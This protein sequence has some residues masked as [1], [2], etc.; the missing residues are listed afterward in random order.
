MS[1]IRVPK[2][3]VM[4]SI[5]LLA[6]RIDTLP[7]A[8]VE[9]DRNT[10]IAALINHFVDTEESTYV[11]EWGHILQCVYYPYLYLRSAREL[12]LIDKILL[13]L[14]R[15]EEPLRAHSVHV[16]D[17][18]LEELHLDSTDFRFAEVASGGFVVGPPTGAKRGA[19]DISEIDLLEE[20]NSIFEFKTVSNSNATVTDYEHWLR[21]G[22]KYTR[23]YK[24]LARSY[25]S[26]FAYDMLPPFVA[27][28][29]HTTYPVSAFAALLRDRDV[30]TGVYEDLRGDLIESL[31]VGKLSR[32][33]PRLG[34]DTST[35]FRS[36]TDDEFAF[37]DAETMKT[38]VPETH[39]YPLYLLAERIWL[40]SSN[41]TRAWLYRPFDFIRDRGHRV[42]P[43]IEYLQPPLSLLFF[44]Y[45]PILR[46]GAVGVVSELYKKA[47]ISS[48]WGSTGDTSWPTV[49]L[50]LYS[51]RVLI[52]NLLAR[53]PPA[54]S[55][56]CPHTACPLYC[57]GLCDGFFIIPKVFGDCEFPVYARRFVHRTYNEQDASLRR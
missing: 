4:P 36:P 30:N 50:T 35:L 1:V 11:H 22:A 48:W 52:Q 10:R 28:S 27:A 51:R 26:Q 17:D 6:L 9:E 49:F 19:Q 31:L 39:Q 53:M 13:D 7:P 33:G 15:S 42:R 24:M 45:E 18:V 21:S 23:T 44:P 25:G 40:H 55:R 38:L 41:P 14:R 20:A 29:Y 43:E 8:G 2:S 47:P 56:F 32:S 34:T 3:F 12:A 46:G 5:G 37:L 16:Q 54:G 57:S